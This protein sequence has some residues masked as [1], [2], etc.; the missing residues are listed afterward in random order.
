MNKEESL[1]YIV[2]HYFKQTDCYGEPQLN[3]AQSEFLAQNQS[4]IKGRIKT[5]LT[6]EGNIHGIGK[7]L[8]ILGE[9]GFSLTDK[10]I[11][12]E[13]YQGLL[14]QDKY[15][16]VQTL[17]KEL[18]IKPTK[19]QIIECWK[20]ALRTP[21]PKRNLEDLT[22]QWGNQQLSQKAV[23]EWGNFW[24][25][26]STGEEKWK[27]S[28]ILSPKE[29]KD[30]ISLLEKVP[31]WDKELAKRAY[32]H[33][34]PTYFHENLCKFLEEDIG[35]EPEKKQIQEHY[36]QILARHKPTRPS[37]S[38]SYEIEQL[39]KAIEITGIQP[40]EEDIEKFY[41]KA[42]KI[43]IEEIKKVEEMTGI[44]MKEEMV[45]KVYRELLEDGNVY[46]INQIKKATGIEEKINESAV[47]KTYEKLFREK[48]IAAAMHLYLHTDI[49][50]NPKETDIIE[51][52][53][54]TIKNCKDKDKNEVTWPPYLEPPFIE[55]LRWLTTQFPNQAKPITQSYIKELISNEE[56]KS[57]HG[58][59]SDLKWAKQLITYLNTDPFP[60]EQYVLACLEANWDV[61]KPLYKKHKT[62]IDQQYPLQAGIMEYINSPQ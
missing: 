45:Q 61:A 7:N 60:E 38:T 13:I 21:S 5:L 12:N 41:A 4:Q 37:N 10:E 35:I 34:L 29:I 6:R 48:N 40:R 57:S 17:S 9:G 31:K 54:E 22:E 51:G 30:C 47:H 18:K 44:K 19:N 53:R 14:D 49:D 11:K 2:T 15:G 8:K 28:T 59:K 20:Q 25:A 58:W 32:H 46:D 36:R 55:Q 16:E 23:N 42:I 33:R 27:Y 50:P 3:D 52:C 26:T 1:E 62:S 56:S 43:N 39:Q 24:L